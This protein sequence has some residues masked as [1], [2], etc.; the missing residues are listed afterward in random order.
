M[1]SAASENH[2]VPSGTV[3]E[4]HWVPSD[5]HKAP[6]SVTKTVKFLHTAATG[7]RNEAWR[8]MSTMSVTYLDVGAWLLTLLRDYEPSVR[9]AEIPIADPILASAHSDRI[10]RRRPCIVRLQ[11]VRYVLACV[12]HSGTSSSSSAP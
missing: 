9:R 10:R 1:S 7:G 8:E 6:V 11:K 5:R 12:G 2:S 3:I 4:R